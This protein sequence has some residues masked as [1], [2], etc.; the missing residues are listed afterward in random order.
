MQQLNYLHQQGVILY[1]KQKDQPEIIFLMPRQDVNHLPVDIKA[2]E[3]RKSVELKKAK[4]LLMYLKN[5]KRC[6]TLQLLDYFGEVSDINCGICDVCVRKRGSLPDTALINKIKHYLK[7]PLTIE[8]LVGS[9][10]TR[11]EEQLISVVREL[12]DQ[13]ILR[14][15]DQFR[16]YLV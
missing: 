12:V 5:D 11:D 8:Q 10:K 13:D 16:L 4:A 14:Y 1:E 15:D 7:D 6:R 9:V 3:L 2:L